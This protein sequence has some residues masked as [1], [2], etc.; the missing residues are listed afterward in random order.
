MRTMTLGL[1]VPRMLQAL[2][3]KWELTQSVQI[4]SNGTPD[5]PILEAY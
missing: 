2:P 5:G 3:A 4:V 1:I